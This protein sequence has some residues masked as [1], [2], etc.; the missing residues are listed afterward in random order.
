MDNRGSRVPVS[1]GNIL[2]TP[3]VI[4][5]VLSI[6]RRTLRYWISK[7]LFPEPLRI[8]PKGRLQRWH[9]DDLLEYLKR[10]RGRVQAEA[11][12]KELGDQAGGKPQGQ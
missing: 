4:Y 2:L 3:D 6:S 10:T 12:L 9:P 7:D 8:G 11:A 5:R 1:S